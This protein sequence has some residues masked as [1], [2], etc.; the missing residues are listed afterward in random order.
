MFKIFVPHPLKRCLDTQ[1]TEAKFYCC[2]GI[3]NFTIFI[4]CHH[5]LGIDPRNLTFI[6]Q[7]VSHQEAY[8]GWV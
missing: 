1:V 5:I 6:H 3:N 8:M 7:T 4:G 2:K